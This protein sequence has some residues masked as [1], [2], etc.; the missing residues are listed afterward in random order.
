MAYHPERGLID[1]FHGQSDLKEGIIRTIGDPSKHF[2]EDVLRILRCLRIAACDHMQIER[3]TA[4]AAVSFAYL[5]ET[6]SNERIFAECDRLLSASG[7]DV[8]KIFHDFYPIWQI[9]FPEIASDFAHWEEII[10]VLTYTPSV[11]NLRWAMLFRFDTSIAQAV[12]ERYPVEHKRLAQILVLIRHSTD[13]LPSNQ[14]EMRQQIANL[15]ADPVRQ[16][17]QMRHAEITR[18]SAAGE[19]QQIQ[20]AE[21]LFKQTLT[22]PKYCFDRK[23]LAVNGNDLIHIG[24]EKGPRIGA[25]L[26]TLFQLVINEEL[27]NQRDVLFNYAKKL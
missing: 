16:L 24:I 12:L 8:S 7:E 5:L 27:P 2:S 25:I 1:R 4:R 23:Q 15:H 21:Q 14:R 10:Q 22:N 19:L 9:I 6:V 3:E 20:Q 11:Q 17:L 13:P 26:D 18:N